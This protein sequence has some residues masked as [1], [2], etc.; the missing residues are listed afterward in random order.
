MCLDES[1]FIT[2]SMLLALDVL[3]LHDFVDLAFLLPVEL[4]VDV[5]CNFSDGQV[6]V[7]QFHN[8]L[9]SILVLDSLQLGVHVEVLGYNFVCDLDETFNLV[10][11]ECCGIV[12]L[13]LEDCLGNVTILELLLL[14]LLLCFLSCSGLRCLNLSR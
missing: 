4:K 13:C 5:P 2:V 12:F 7:C 10:A 9:Q 11:G 1:L 3:L 8:F 6:L 14:L